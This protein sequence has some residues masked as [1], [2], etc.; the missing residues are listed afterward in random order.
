MRRELN[1]NFLLPRQHG[2]LVTP[3]NEILLFGGRINE[4]A[5]NRSFVLSG[6]TL[7]ELAPMNSERYDFGI[8]Y[9]EDSV[10]VAGGCQ[11]QGNPMSKF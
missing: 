8:C 5:T 6:D 4:I 1:I 10:Y 2:S 11:A 7:A 9:H 3:E